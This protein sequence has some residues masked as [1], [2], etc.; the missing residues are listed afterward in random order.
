MWFL[1]LP[2]IP[3]VPV[4]PTLIWAEL[5]MLWFRCHKLVSTIITVFNSRARS[6]W[7]K[8]CPHDYKVTGHGEPSDLLHGWLVRKQHN[9]RLS[10]THSYHSCLFE[11]LHNHMQTQDLLLPGRFQKPEIHLSPGEMKPEERGSTSSSWWR[12]KILKIPS[13]WSFLCIVDV[14]ISRSLL[15]LAFASQAHFFW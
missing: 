5:K 3:N 4:C 1:V 6:H 9:Y 2:I 13:F 10:V 7:F 15:V 11:I 14:Y 12:W 8:C